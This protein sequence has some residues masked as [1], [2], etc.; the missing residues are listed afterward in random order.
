MQNPTF[1]EAVHF[2]GHRCPGLAFGCRAAEIAMEKVGAVRAPDEELVAIVENDACGVDGIQVVTGCTVG[3]G[4]LILR[5]LGKGAWTLINRTSG[6][7]VRIMTRPDF[8]VDAVDPAFHPLRAKIHGGSATPAEREAYREHLDAVCAAILTRPADEVF[9]VREVAPD[10]P[11]KARIFVSYTCAVCGEQVA[12]S[13]ARVKDGK[14]VCIPCA[15]KY[16]RGW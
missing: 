14:I 13:R 1:E 11:E 8:S 4:N 9:A 6:K 7:A 5:D 12:E 3:K 2:H 10:V 16:T 15:G